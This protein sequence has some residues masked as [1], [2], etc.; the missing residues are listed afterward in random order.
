[1]IQ[2]TL[3]LFSGLGFL[4]LGSHLLVSSLKSLSLF[5]KLKPLFLS[6]IV[7]GFVSS[8]PEW[9]VT[10][11]A[12]VKGS[13][14]AALGNIFGSNVINILL[15]LAL[16]GLF[17]KFSI[18]RQ[19]IYF[20]MPVLI[21]SLCIFGLFSI[22]KKIG[23]WE[24]VILLGIFSAYLW[25]LFRKRKDSPME[26]FSSPANYSFLK[27]LIYLILGFITLF[28]GSSLAVNSS[29][30][31]VKTFSLSE[32]FAG[33]FI[34][35]LSTSLPELAT[36]LQAVFKKEGEMALGNIV[37][38]NLFN[39]LFVL[40]SAS[41]FHPLY[42]SKGLYFDYYFMFLVTLIL[43]SVLSL[44]KKI[45]KIIFWGFIVSYFFYIAFVS[46]AL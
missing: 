45:P 24:G 6:I 23:L 30:S 39:T 27:S 17:Y 14:D 1:M 34:L 28:A 43:W 46:G 44:F 42:F 7:L 38:S 36:T 18:D 16:A 22:D 19:I 15:I 12:S 21:S 8:S 9:F 37:G 41:L 35:S 33:V 40:G 5:F 32:R 2:D 13:S 29:L 11:T 10:L 25:F 4:I 20:D 26:Q 31:L 3:F